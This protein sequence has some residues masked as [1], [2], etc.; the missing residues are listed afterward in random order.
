MAKAPHGPLP[1]AFPG[2]RPG[3]P[4]GPGKGPPFIPPRQRTR[5][6]PEREK[7]RERGLAPQTRS[8][9]CRA[10]TPSPTGGPP[11]PQ[12]PPPPTRSGPKSAPAPR[13]ARGPCEDPPG[14]PAYLGPSAPTPNPR[15]KIF[16]YSGGNALFRR[17]PGHFR[18]KAKGKRGGNLKDFGNP[19]LLSR[20]A[21]PFCGRAPGPEPS[22]GVGAASKLHRPGGSYPAPGPGGSVDS[23]G[24]PLGSP[25]TLGPNICGVWGTRWA[26]GAPPP[27]WKPWAPCQKGV[28]LTR[29]GGYAPRRE[30]I[31]TDRPWPCPGET[32]LPNPSGFPPSRPPGPF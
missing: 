31:S 22:P 10:G 1:A 27:R 28:L 21:P 16:S 26:G 7:A 14:A 17:G 25:P 11:G 9:P 19:P 18:P 8:W 5:Y 12:G 32:P 20:A 6:P 29:N 30:P 2:P 24:D 23:P 3:R 13:R 15:P 4:R